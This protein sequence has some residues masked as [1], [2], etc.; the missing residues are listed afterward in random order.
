M[1][2]TRERKPR[3][4]QY[5]K[6]S[7]KFKANEGD[8]VVSIQLGRKKYVVPVKVRFL[9]A[10]GYLFLSFPASANLFRVSED[11]LSAMANEDDAQEAYEKLRTRKTRGRKAEAAEVTLPTEL[12]SALAAIPSGF[13]LGYGPDGTPR[14]VKTRT[15]TKK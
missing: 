10:D 7:L 11:G 5:V 14:L 4:V 8:D 15:R 6:N 13:K 9:S 2:K 12:A 1:R 3:T